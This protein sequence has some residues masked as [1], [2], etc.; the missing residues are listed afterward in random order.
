MKQETNTIAGLLNPASVA[1]IG[2]SEDQAKYGGR[3]LHMLVKHR[4]GGA[5]Y[6]IN[7]NR[8]ELFGLTAYPSVSATPSAPEMVI[9]AVP[10]AQVKPLIAECA[11][12][13]VRCAIVITAQFSDAGPEGAALER[14]VVEIAAAAGLRLIGPNCLGLI[15][16][17][18]SL[19]LCSSPA[20][21][22]DAMP[23]GEIG[24]VTQSGAFMGTLFDRAVSMGIGFSH[25]F[26]VGNQA[27]LELC[28]FVEMLIDDPH[29]R[30]ICTYIEGVKSP[31]RLV[32]LARRARAAGKPWLAVKAGRTAAG[33]AAAFSHTASLAGDYAVLKSVCD[34]ENIVLLNDVFAMLLLAGSMALHPGHRVHEAVLISTSGGSAALSADSLSDAGIPMTRFSEDTA[35][36]LATLYVKGQADNPVDLFGG[37]VREVLDFSYQSAAM[38]MRDPKADVCLSVITTAPRLREMAAELAQ[39]AQESHK[40]IFQVMQPGALAAG[41]REVL[42]LAGQPFTDSIAEAVEAI[43]AWRAWS[44][45]QEV[46]EDEAPQVKL[47]LPAAATNSAAELGED[48]SKALLAAAGVPTVRGSI[49]R[50]VDDALRQADGVGFPIVLKIVSPQIVHKTEVGGVE[51]NL[52]NPGELKAALETMQARIQREAPQAR[53]DGYFLQQMVSGSVEILVGARHDAQFGP[54]VIVGSGGVMVELLKDVVLLPLPL[55]RAAAHEALMSLRIAPLLNGYRG[56]EPVDV[57]AVV[58]AVMRFAAIARQMEGR[59]FE[60]EVNPLIAG[61]KGCVAVDARARIGGMAS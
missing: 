14:E 27:D 58:D 38:S 37:K 15:S 43:R 35:A 19:V 51:L 55:T 36:A 17:A 29:T 61:P 49:A 52:R 20:L 11:A 22:V 18:N 1:V 42:R 6:P 10:R 7:P 39:G 28:D 25:C 9:M 34:R 21:D 26:S 53:I 54:M 56:A 46:V 12:R 3:V 45:F 30:V 40:P 8:S 5:I 59:D 23:R 57:N 44:A 31:Q 13:G 60:I 47:K 41:A 48:A 16:P 50:D 32:Q 24:F 4:Y 33:S 2:A